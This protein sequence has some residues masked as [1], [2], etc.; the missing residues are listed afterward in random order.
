MLL[1]TGEAAEQAA[2]LFYRIGT[3]WWKWVKQSTE[4]EE[5]GV[6]NRGRIV[7]IPKATDR[8]AVK[9]LSAPAEAGLKASTGGTTLVGLSDWIGMTLTRQLEDANSRLQAASPSW[10]RSVRSRRSSVCSVQLSAF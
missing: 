1:C 3:D 8:D 6:E 4:P 2:I 9:T 5:G 10:V 7:G